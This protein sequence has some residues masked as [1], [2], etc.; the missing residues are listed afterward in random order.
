MDKIIIE[1][2]CVKNKH[3]YEI[4]G[5]EPLYNF[6][7]KDYHENS[8]DTEIEIYPDF[9]D[10]RFEAYKDKKIRITIEEVE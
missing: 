9:G 6:I 7:V 4:Y 8:N 3:P 10:N 1:G 5:L 2:I